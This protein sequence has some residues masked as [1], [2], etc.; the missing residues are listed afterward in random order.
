MKLSKAIRLGSRKVKECRGQYFLT[1][2]GK[3]TSACAVGTALIG[4]GNVHDDFALVGKL[5]KK[6]FGDEKGVSEGDI[7][8][9]HNNGESRESIAASLERMG[10]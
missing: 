10:R 6:Y 8:F 7:V 3:V 1:V 4:V 5:F 2:G 9:R